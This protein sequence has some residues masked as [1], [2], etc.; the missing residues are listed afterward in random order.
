V[1]MVADSITKEEAAKLVKKM[2]N[3]ST[4]KM[5]P[6]KNMMANL[7]WVLFTMV[8]DIDYS[9]V[10]IEEGEAEKLLSEPFDVEE[11]F[12]FNP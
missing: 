6:Q 8:E 11:D 10:N 3:D 12:A 5:K 4:A 1:N 9:N 7:L 2:Q